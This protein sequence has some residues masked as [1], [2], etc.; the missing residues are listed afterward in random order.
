MYVHDEITQRSCKVN[1]SFFLFITPITSFK[2][3]RI[4]MSLVEI[5]AEA[6]IWTA[7]WKLS[8]LVSKQMNDPVVLVLFHTTMIVIAFCVLMLTTGT[9]LF[10]AKSKQ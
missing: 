3:A 9:R 4:E 2:V 10:P 6:T 7:V 5:L 1:S 8:D